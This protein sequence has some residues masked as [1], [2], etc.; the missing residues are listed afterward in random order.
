MGNDSYLVQY[1]FSW[2]KEPFNKIRDYF[3]VAP[4]TDMMV[5]EDPRVKMTF[6]YNLDGEK[7]E[8]LQ[9]GTY[10]HFTVSN[11][12]M[13]QGRKVEIIWPYKITYQTNGEPAKNLKGYF[14][15]YARLNNKYT[16]DNYIVYAQFYHGKFEI[17]GS[18]S[19]GVS[20][21]GSSA[22]FSISPS[23]A[24]VTETHSMDVR[25]K[26]IYK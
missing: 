8:T 10:N 22:S 25:A 9:D 23:F 6:K 15:Y 21:T 20:I 16:Y 12:S 11:L 17:I 19:I 3:A 7:V 13:G 5:H 18:A 2:E 24:F 1:R 14:T 26:N 4:A